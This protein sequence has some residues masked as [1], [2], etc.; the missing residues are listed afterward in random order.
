MKSPCLL[1]ALLMLGSLSAV[2]QLA[3]PERLEQVRQLFPAADTNNDGILTESEARVFYTKM[4]P[5]AAA[6]PSVAPA[7]TFANASYGPHERN[8]LDFWQA[9]SDQ[10]TPLVVYIHGGGFVA[11][12]KSG[13]RKDRTSSNTSTAGVSFAA[14]NYRYRTTTSDPGRAPRLRAGDP[15]PAQQVGG[16]EHRQDPR[17]CLRRLGRRGHFAVARLSR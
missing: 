8:V 3:T 17:R 4:R 15:I 5:A 7:P 14:I 12:D 9:K 2:A 10:P 6:A 16:V 11:G 1:T 13:V